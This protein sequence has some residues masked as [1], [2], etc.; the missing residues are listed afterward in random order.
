MT[1]NEVKEQALAILRKRYDEQREQVVAIDARLGEYYDDLCEHSSGVAGDENDWH[2]LDEVL[3]GVMFLRLLRTYDF[4]HEKVWQVI[5]DCEGKWEERDGRWCHVEGGLKQ[6]GRQGPV[7][8]R[9][10]P[11]QV[12][13]L[14]EMYGPKGWIDT[15][16]EAG[17]RELMESEREKDGRIEDLRRLC[18][19]FIAFLPRKTNK[20]GF[21]ALTNCEDF[22]R[23]DYDAQVFCCANSQQQSKILFQ[24]T[25]ELIRQLDPK[26]KRIRFTGTEVTW[27]PGQFRQSSLYALSAGGKTKDGT[28][29]S[30]CCA[31]E[32]GSAGYVNNKSDMG[33]L[34]KVIESSM[35]P[36]RE[37]MTL[38]TTTAGNIEQGPFV[39][40]LE[41]TQ[42]ELRREIGYDSGEDTPSLEGDRRM[43]L[44]LH[45]DEWEMD[46]EVMLSERHIR[47]KVNPMLGVIVQHS[48]YDQMIDSARRDPLTMQEVVSKL[49]NV[50]RTGHV[51]EWLTPDAISMLQEKRRVDDC[52]AKDGWVVFC[53]L[54]FSKGDD[55]NGVSYLCVNLKTATFFADMDSYMSE[56]AMQ[57]SPLRGLFES[58][59]DAGWLHVVPGETFDPTWPVDRI[60]ELTG[61][62]VNFMGFGYDPYNAKIVTNALGAWVREL[63]HD[64]KDFIIPVR[65]NFA[66][67]NPVVNELD[68][69]VKR[70]VMDNDGHYVA[71]PMIHFS[72]NPLWPWEF[73]N[74]VL[75]ESSDRL[76]RKPVK[77]ARSGSGKV[78]NIQMLLSALV[79]YDIADGREG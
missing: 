55:L 64:P 26:G 3:S 46:E 30:R 13:M 11:F 74:C 70:S 45:P 6:P 58:W 29:A 50:Y 79:L 62:G 37:P 36:R 4:D 27:K 54:D 25:A 77:R 53:G 17:S 72:E 49:F 56:H 18:V 40:I 9:L 76:S 24:R 28:F 23:G 67:Y 8:Y 7:V 35:G 73:G 47:R 42:R 39:E 16:N 63:G 71:A 65:Q 75:A 60:I 2:N 19:Y 51:L 32:F 38:V 31:D 57:S 69:M 43:C 10:V 48:F 21:S 41:S 52:L 5:D 15:G 20:T 1:S 12:F 61:K 34:V 78:D 59:R 33:S 44:L 66:T 68:Y 14:C 22:M